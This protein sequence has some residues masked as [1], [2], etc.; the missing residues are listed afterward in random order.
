LLFELADPVGE[1]VLVKMGGI[2][3]EV[4]VGSG[5]SE[6]DEVGAVLRQD[7]GRRY[8]GWGGEVIR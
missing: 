8:S 6:E 3:A 2:V 5:G 7:L 1:G 4:L